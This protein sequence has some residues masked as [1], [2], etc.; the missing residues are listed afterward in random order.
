MAILEV[1]KAGNPVLKQVAKPIKKIDSRLRRLMD[2]MAETMYKCDGVGLAAPQVGQSIRL[3]VID[4]G[5]GIIELIN[6]VI[7]HREGKVTDSE[8][9][10]SVPG[11]FGAVE[12]TTRFN[13]RR[14][15]KADGL[16]ARC[17]QHECDHLEGTLFIDIAKS[18]RQ[19]SPEDRENG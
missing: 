16:L 1:V 12:Y 10:L 6:P 8:G 7:T 14:T 15:L 19:E 13:K 2:D 17:I 18:L 11:I 4:V 9:C 3:V 5:E